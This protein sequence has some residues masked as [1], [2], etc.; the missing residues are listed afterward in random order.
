M[1][2]NASTT[3]LYLGRPCKLVPDWFMSRVLTTSTGVLKMALT[4]PAP[5]DAAKCARGP[6]CMTLED[7]SQFLKPS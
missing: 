4:I 3:P 1:F 2:K 6:S 5:A 7:S